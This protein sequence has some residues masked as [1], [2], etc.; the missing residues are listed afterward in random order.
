MQRVGFVVVYIVKHEQSRNRLEAP[1]LKRFWKEQR[2]IRSECFELFEVNKVFLDGFLFVVIGRPL[3][4]AGEPKE[5]PSAPD[6]DVMCIY[7]G[8]NDGDGSCGDD[9]LWGERV[10]RTADEAV[11]I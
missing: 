7:T 2:K 1:I 10:S 6:T 5:G 3:D 4:D 9:S 8:E 11:R